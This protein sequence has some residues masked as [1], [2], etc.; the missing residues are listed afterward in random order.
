MSV[1]KLRFSKN[2]I[3]AK[4]EERMEEA[5]PVNETRGQM[6]QRHK[7]ELLALKK[8]RGKSQKEVKDMEKQLREKHKKELE[9]LEKGS[10][11]APAS[12]VPVSLAPQSSQ[13]GAG[14]KKATRK[15][16]RMVVIARVVGSLIRV[17]T[18][19]K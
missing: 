15:Q 7:K 2:Q 19:R 3:V 11:D 16:R 18:F 14:Q 6:T 4:K 12:V 8:V 1:N 9:N 13:E 17:F 5:P 10:Q